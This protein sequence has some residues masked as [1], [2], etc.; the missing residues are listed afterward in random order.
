MIPDDGLNDP[1]PPFPLS[2]GV[3]LVAIGVAW[4]VLWRLGGCSP[5]W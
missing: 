3:V 1:P 5:G 4:W 2:V